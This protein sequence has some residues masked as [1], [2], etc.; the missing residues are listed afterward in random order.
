[1]NEPPATPPPGGK[2]PFFW[3][4]ALNLGLLVLAALLT[5]AEP[6]ALGIMVLVLVVVNTI[7]AGIMSFAGRIHFVIAFL[8]SALVVGL[9][10]FGVCALM[11]SHIGGGH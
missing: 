4:V 5:G 3:P 7:A 2:K 9:V 10:G 8:L 11:L 6:G 1:M